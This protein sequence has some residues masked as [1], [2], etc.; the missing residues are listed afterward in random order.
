M[1]LICFSQS[2][3]IDFFELVSNDEWSI[4]AKN[5][6]RFTRSFGSEDL[7][8]KVLKFWTVVLAAWAVL[9]YMSLSTTNSNIAFNCDIL[10]Y[11]IILYHKNNIDCTIQ[12]NVHYFNFIFTIWLLLYIKLTRHTR[13]F[14]WCRSVVVMLLCNTNYYWRMI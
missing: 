6:S 7:V 11:I 14:I 4:M 12:K 5:H 9:C 10:W 2:F 13:V 1:T 8:L 3:S